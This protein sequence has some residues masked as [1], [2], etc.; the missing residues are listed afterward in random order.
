M[1]AANVAAK[2]VIGWTSVVSQL[3]VKVREPSASTPD[4]AKSSASPPPGQSS[5]MPPLAPRAALWM[6][7]PLTSSRRLGVSDGWPS[8]GPQSRPLT[9]TVTDRLVVALSKMATP[10]PVADDITTGT[11]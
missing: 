3:L 10:S 11:C 7:T 9:L 1:A 6:C 5:T 4:T 8:N 2:G